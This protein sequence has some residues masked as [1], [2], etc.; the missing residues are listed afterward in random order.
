MIDFFILASCF[1]PL[2]QK[3][4]KIIKA[5]PLI[6]CF[7]MF[8]LNVLL[9]LI[10]LFFTHPH[11]LILMPLHFVWD[12]VQIPFAPAELIQP[13]PYPAVEEVVRTYFRILRLARFCRFVA[14]IISPELKPWIYFSADVLFC[15][16]DRK[17][18][19]VLR[20]SK[21][22]FTEEGLARKEDESLIIIDIY[23]RL[24]LYG[25]ID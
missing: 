25:R 10:T 4:F 19:S 5:P 11:E 8:F 14:P 17:L 7:S 18:E 23:R 22:Y 20:H 16:N 21:H 3:F 12:V 24:Y 2:I 9:N 1:C 15:T 6:L 13:C